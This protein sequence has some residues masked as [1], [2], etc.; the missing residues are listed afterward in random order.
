ME[1]HMSGPRKVS[2]RTIHS[3]MAMLLVA[4]TTQSGIAQQ[5][6]TPS[7]QPNRAGQPDAAKPRAKDPGLLNVVVLATGGTIAGAAASDVTAGY[8]S[9]QVGVEQLLDAVPQARKLANLSGEQIAN[10]GS[11]DMNDETWIKLATRINEVLARPD[12]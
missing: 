2:R 12:V 5:Q 7:P 1:E 3:L 8:T 10:I 4:A 9:G 11:Q 6:G